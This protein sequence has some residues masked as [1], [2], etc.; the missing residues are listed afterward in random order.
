MTCDNTCRSHA[1]RRAAVYMQARPRKL[2]RKR[3]RDREGTHTSAQLSIQWTVTQFLDYYIECMHLPIHTHTHTHRAVMIQTLLGLVL[4]LTMHKLAAV[5]MQHSIA[6]TTNNT[7]RVY[8]LWDES[9]GYTCLEPFTATFSWPPSLTSR[10]L[11]SPRK[12]HRQLSCGVQ[13][14]PKQQVGW[15]R[16]AIR[17]RTSNKTHRNG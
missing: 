11:L 6:I 14:S 7:F 17:A 4:L 15:P 5:M 10:Q 2:E 13:V 1:L 12:G 3:D 16:E 9:S 8:S